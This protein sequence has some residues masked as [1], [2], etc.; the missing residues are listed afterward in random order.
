MELKEKIYAILG[1]CMGI[2]E[3]LPKIPQKTSGCV[4]LWLLFFLQGS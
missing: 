3:S 1:G 4:L 2:V